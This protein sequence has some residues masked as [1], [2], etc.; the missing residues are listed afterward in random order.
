M[1]LEVAIAVSVTAVLLGI[2]AAVVVRL[3][4]RAR[5]AGRDEGYVLG[6]RAGYAAGF[7]EME[8]MLVRYRQSVQVVLRSVQSAGGEVPPSLLGPMPP[9]TPRDGRARV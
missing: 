6:H 1:M 9:S 8:A 3:V 4:R 2:A 7:A 5:V